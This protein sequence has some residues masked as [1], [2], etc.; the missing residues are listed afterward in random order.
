ME[1][2]RG[3]NRNIFLVFILFVLSVGISILIVDK[4]PFF[5]A[6]GLELL[7]QV[8]DRIN[9]GKFP[10]ELEYLYVG[11]STCR[12]V[13]EVKE[14]DLSLCIEGR[15]PI[16]VLGMAEKV[17]SQAKVKTVVFSFLRYNI[18]KKEEQNFVHFVNFEHLKEVFNLY[19][20]TGS[21]S[22]FYDGVKFSFRSLNKMAKSK[23]SSTFRLRFKKPQ[24]ENKFKDPS[25]FKLAYNPLFPCFKKD[26]SFKKDS[27]FEAFKNNILL[28]CLH[29]HTKEKLELKNS[30]NLEK[31]K[32]SIT[33]IKKISPKT[34]IIFMIPP[35]L[36]WVRVDPEIEKLSRDASRLI[37]AEM[38]NSYV[39]I[40]NYDLWGIELMANLTHANHAGVAIIRNDI[41]RLKTK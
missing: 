5:S 2:L 34:Q 1:N 4:T 17:V 21:N 7:F 23:V 40:L 32:H 27:S 24:L 38:R 39:K 29:E 41:E 3:P 28:D 13:F 22:A 20:K 9:N 8:R 16:E 19:E 36:D 10:K 31:I 12:S 35:V 6:G 11:D 25:V 18:L 15:P 14:D 37:L 30:L 33:K 26:Y